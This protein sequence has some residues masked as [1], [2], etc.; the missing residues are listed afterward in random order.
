MK[1]R[2]SMRQFIILLLCVVLVACA[3]ST[4][5]KDYIV[6]VN[7]SLE[8]LVPKY[9]AYIQTPPP[10]P[11]KLDFVKN[12]ATTD[13]QQKLQIVALFDYLKGI[14]RYDDKEKAAILDSYTQ[15]LKTAKLA[16]EE[17]QK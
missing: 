2:F 14:P 8:V 16:A 5:E 15:L 9:L 6:T 4:K 7:R 13:E 12:Y 17:A 11:A 3:A 10:D 1:G